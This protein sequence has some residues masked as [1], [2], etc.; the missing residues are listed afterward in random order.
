MPPD[1]A[2]PPAV[3][4]AKRALLIVSIPSPEAEPRP[5]HMTIKIPSAR[6]FAM[7]PARMMTAPTKKW[8]AG[9]AGIAPFANTTPH[10]VGARSKNVP[11]GLSK[12]MIS[13]APRHLVAVGG[14]GRQARQSGST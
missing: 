7:H 12:R 3:T 4:E 5:L 10:S 13:T 6:S 11:I 9:A 2:Q 1:P 8:L 14:W